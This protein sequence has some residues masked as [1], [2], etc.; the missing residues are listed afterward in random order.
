MIA[1]SAFAQPAALK[2]V[3]TGPDAAA[4]AQRLVVHSERLGRDFVVVVSAP[5]GP[6]L[7][8]GRKVAAIYAL[9]GGHGVAG[10]IGQ[11]M[12]WSGTMSP[13]YVVSVG[14]PDGQAGERD[15]DLLFR[16]TVRDGVTIGG[17]GSAFEAF[18]TTELRPFLEAR[19]PLDPAKAI[20]FGHSYGGLFAANVLADAPRAFAGYIIASASVPADAQMLAGLA[21]AVPKGDGRRVYVAVGEREDAGTVEGAKR[22]AAIL[23]GPGSTFVVE[24]HVFAGEGH[25]AYYPQL[26]PAAFAWILPPP[27]APAVTHRAVV[28]SPA[29]LKRLAGD[30]VTADGRTVTV[31]VRQGKLYAQ[32]TGSPEGEFRPETP[33]SFYTEATPGFDITLTFQA[34]EG[35][36][37]GALVF[38]V[39]GAQTRA[40][41][42]LTRPEP[43]CRRLAGFRLVTAPPACRP[44][45]HRPY[46]RHG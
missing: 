20:L 9:D 13:A 18:L 40:V 27:T 39:N 4:G 15:T 24:S 21:P 17:G 11:L 45:A 29:A 3:S 25:I 16:P 8:P 2:I 32:L 10:P 46:A 31:A 30:Y 12:A 5:S 26:V 33:V 43:A 7:Q 36:P 1:A 28:V 44:R 41:R 6:F 35:G 42:T 34:A 23:A 14:Y 19:Y 38:S 37:P 22:I